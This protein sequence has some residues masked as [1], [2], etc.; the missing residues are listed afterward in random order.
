MLTVLFWNIQKKPLLDRVARIVRTHAV[1]VVVLAECV[2]TDAEL[3]AT[4]NMG[5]GKKFRCPRRLT[6]KF[7]IAFSNPILRLPHRRDSVGE[8]MSFYEPQ[9][10]RKPSFILA[11]AHLP[12]KQAHRDSVVQEIAGDLRRTEM[13]LKHARTVV[14]GDF[15]RSPF[16]DVMV[17]ALGFHALMTRDLADRRHLRTV[18]GVEYPT[19]FNPMWRFLTDRGSQPAGTYYFHPSVPTNHF[20]Y[21]LDQVLVRPEV[22]DKLSSVEVLESDGADSLLDSANRWPDQSAGSDHLPLLVRL[23]W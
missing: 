1:D 10:R 6:D 7:R 8:H 11:I 3:L 21:A 18:A 23:D 15:N 9:F 2:Q 4:L 16:D 19:F 12:S 13:R 20:W 5:V 14:V 17:D 22:A